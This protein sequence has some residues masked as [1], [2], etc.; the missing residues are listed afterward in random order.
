MLNF[1]TFMECVNAPDSA[2]LTS[3]GVLAPV[4]LA[5]SLVAAGAL[6]AR[7]DRKRFRV[8]RS[9]GVWTTFLI[10]VY[11][12]IVLAYFFVFS[13][14]AIM[15][16]AT[17]GIENTFWVTAVVM[18]GIGIAGLI[19][20]VGFAFGGWLVKTKQP[21]SAPVARRLVIAIDGP[22]AS[23]KGTVAKR[24]AAHL[25]LPCLD[26]GLLYR[27]VAPA[28]VA[29]GG[30]LENEAA[31]TAAARSLDAAALDDPDLR[32]PAAGDAASIVAKMPGVR[33]A[34]LEYQRAFASQPGGAVLDGRD[35][36]TV[37]CPNADVKIFVTATSEERARRRHLEHQSR[38]EDISYETV[39]ADIR[40]RDERDSARDVAPLEAATD[41][42]TLDTTALD[43]DAAFTAALK[44]VAAKRR[45]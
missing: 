29:K 35:I 32:G 6:L 13:P 23:G 31:A 26:T 21:I 2:C 9:M 28:V 38:G 22:A 15:G 34:L 44:I 40:R 36:G 14:D 16:V 37:I 4:V 24:M 17:S 20:M 11:S 30:A 45:A 39:L 12:V 41:A 3:P 5:L 8:L 42:I 27:A 43:A 1:V 7:R 18:Y 33:A 19:G 10:L 25:N